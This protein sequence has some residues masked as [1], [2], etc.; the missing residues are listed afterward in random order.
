MTT[1]KKNKFKNRVETLA[2]IAATGTKIAQFIAS[3]Y[4]FPTFKLYN[5]L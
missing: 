5:S 4:V 3:F 2:A 1:T